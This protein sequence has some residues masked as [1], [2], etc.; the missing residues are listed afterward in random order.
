MMR[1]SL[2]TVCLGGGLESKLA[3]APKAGFRAEG[4]KSP[5]SDVTKFAAFSSTLSVGDDGVEASRYLP[6]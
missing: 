1:W 2:A 4:V 3:A 6:P 5:S